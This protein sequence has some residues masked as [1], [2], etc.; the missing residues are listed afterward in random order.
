MYMIISQLKHDD[1]CTC[2]GIMYM[3]LIVSF[4][5]LLPLFYPTMYMFVRNSKK[6]AL[7]IPTIYRSIRKTDTSRQQKVH[8]LYENV[9]FKNYFH[10]FFKKILANKK[11]N[12]YFCT[13]LSTINIIMGNLNNTGYKPVSK[14]QNIG[15][16][17]KTVLHDLKDTLEV[18][19]SDNLAS[20]RNHKYEYVI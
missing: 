17:A 7:V 20:I 2:L 19:S 18:L 6:I 5:I 10:A 13:K 16:D 9:S 8:H 12:S 11:I 1:P 4:P 15:S 14:L 3:L